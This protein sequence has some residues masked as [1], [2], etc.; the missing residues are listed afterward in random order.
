MFDLLW[1]SLK[2]FLIF[3]IV[4]AV[5][6]GLFLY[7]RISGGIKRCKTVKAQ[8]GDKIELMQDWDSALGFY[9]TFDSYGKAAEANPD[10]ILL[11]FPWMAQK[12][13]EARGE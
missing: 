1:N 7:I 2:N 6:G 5:I 13:A 4:A 10:P 8:L 3:L 9:Q 12:F 11:P